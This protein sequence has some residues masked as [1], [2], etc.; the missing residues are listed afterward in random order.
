V[1]HLGPQRRWLRAVGADEV[2]EQARGR[3]FEQAVPERLEV[4][5]DFFDQRCR[6]GAV[7]GQPSARV[8][9]ADADVAHLVSHGEPLRLAQARKRADAIELRRFAPAS[10]PTATPPLTL[11]VMSW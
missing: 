3:V 9:D 4:L 7:M 2:V 11:S 1:E 6:A 10:S 5:D 8:G